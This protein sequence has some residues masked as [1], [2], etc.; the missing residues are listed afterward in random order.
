[1]KK[2]NENINP[3]WVRDVYLKEGQAAATVESFAPTTEDVWIATTRRPIEGQRP[4]L[5]IAR[6]EVQ[7]KAA[8]LKH[9]RR[10]N[11]SRKLV[12]SSDA[13]AHCILMQLEPA[14]FPEVFPGLSFPVRCWEDLRLVYGAYVYPVAFG[15]V[16]TVSSTSSSGDVISDAIAH[17]EH[18]DTG[19]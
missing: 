12:Q 7:A 19:D 11:R 6:T 16:C 17:L 1:M 15:E 5:L 10:A 18:P 4:Q 9:W 3:E 2:P 13:K 8:L 14:D